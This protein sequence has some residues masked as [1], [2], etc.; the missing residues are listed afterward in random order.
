[1]ISAAACLCSN[2]HPKVGGHP[3]LRH[4]ATIFLVYGN[5]TTMFESQAYGNVFLN[6]HT[7][8]NSR[9]RRQNDSGEI[10]RKEVGVS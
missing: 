10:R 5:W 6:G 3:K 7:S 1:V 4:H 2:L 8:S 9:C